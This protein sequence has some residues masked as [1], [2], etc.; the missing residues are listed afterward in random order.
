MYAQLVTIMD[1]EILI[2]SI[3]SRTYF[4][5][6]Q[7]SICEGEPRRLARALSRSTIS[8][9]F[10]LDLALSAQLGTLDSLSLSS[11]ASSGRTVLH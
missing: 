5:P 3:R 8:S 7:S 4:E 2:M 10:H 11:T 1:S 9:R 6:A